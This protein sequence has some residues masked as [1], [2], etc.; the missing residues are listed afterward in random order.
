MSSTQSLSKRK[1]PILK[2]DIDDINSDDGITDTESN[3]STP[4]TIPEYLQK[5]FKG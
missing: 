1:R 3:T 4:I 2:I 5:L